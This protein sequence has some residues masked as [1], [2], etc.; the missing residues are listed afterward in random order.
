MI[1][2]AMML[3][4]EVVDTVV[5]VSMRLVPAPRWKKGRTGFASLSKP[6]R[7]WIFE[8]VKCTGMK[9]SLTTWKHGEWLEPDRVWLNIWTTSEK[10]SCKLITDFWTFTYLT[11]PVLFIS[12]SAQDST[13]QISVSH[14]TCKV[15]VLYLDSCILKAMTTYPSTSNPPQHESTDNNPWIHSFFIP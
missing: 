1:R 13:R 5:D 8:S 12:K 2:D 4:R 15:L 14:L 10:L 9:R 7:E 6:H 11:A 3:I